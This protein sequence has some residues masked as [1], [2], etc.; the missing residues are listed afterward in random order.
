MMRFYCFIE[1]LMKNKIDSPKIFVSYAWGTESYQ[2][3]VVDFC[4]RL[5]GDGIDVILDKW[6][7]DLGNDTNDY[8]EKCVSDESIH[9]VLLLLD[10]TY[11]EKA[12]QR[13]GGVG[14]E[15]QI[16]SEEVY[17]KVSQTKYIPIIFELD[18]N[19]D[20]C[21]PF[22][23]K[24][25]LF[26][27]LSDEANYEKQ[28]QYLVRKLYGR[29]I[30]IKPE[31]GTMPK[32]VDEPEKVDTVLLPLKK[33][34]DSD[35]VSFAKREKS[36]L[37]GLNEIIKDISSFDA[38]IANSSSDDYSGVYLKR[39]DE[40]K[41]IRDKFLDFIEAG[42]SLESFTE[43]ISSFLENA[44]TA[45]NDTRLN[46]P[47]A[48]TEILLFLIQEMFIYVVA[49]LFK[50]RCYTQIDE[51]IS[52]TY[53]KTEFGNTPRA[54]TFNMFYCTGC[55]NMKSILNEYENKNFVSAIAELWKRREYAPSISFHEFVFA[56]ELLFNLDAMRFKK[57]YYWFPLSYPYRNNLFAIFAI[58]L[59]SKKQLLLAKDLFG[60]SDIQEIKN[61][62][63]KA[64]EVAQKDRYSF[65]RSFESANTIA[66]H[67]KIEEI[68]SLP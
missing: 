40:T 68:G 45:I 1:V 51:L 56:D 37:Q 19:G 34:V 62:I 25:R 44:Y 18:E 31:L 55:D 42:I 61:Q 54:T 58:K 39:F 38:V 2:Q 26:I 30:I 57:D 10:K 29:E 47:H 60:T 7:L 4:K 35:T 36:F 24:S 59:K 15:T 67:I 14:K 65:E 11:S 21:I 41:P 6:N 20:K 32:W 63:T 46:K 17:N 3:K 28:Y 12:N 49:M 8:M 5:V 48:H 64:Q 23:L 27:D 52:R 9:F 43:D 22:Y 53:F 16:I 33:V 13:R 66:R 50:N